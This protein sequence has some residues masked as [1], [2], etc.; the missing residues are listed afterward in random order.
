[1]KSILEY[2]DQP[3][4][5]YHG[6][7]IQNLKILKPKN[8]STHDKSKINRVY[9]ADTKQIASAFT[10]RWDD[11]TGI[12]CG[13]VGNDSKLITLEIPKN[14]L[15]LL[16]KPCSIYTVSPKFFTRSTGGFEEYYT[17]QQINV[18]SEEQ[19]N[20]SKEAIEKYKCRIKII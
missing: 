3:K 18:V 13:W 8:N 5:L 7:D 14:F 10:F 4:Y 6:S 16:D 1:L 12:K 19:F 11:S 20:S 2:V 9:V 15:Y 17:T